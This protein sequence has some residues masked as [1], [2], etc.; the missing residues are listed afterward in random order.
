VMLQTPL[1][2]TPIAVSS[3]VLLAVLVFIFLGVG[4]CESNALFVRRSACW[5]CTC[6]LPTSA[7]CLVRGFVMCDRLFPPFASRTVDVATAWHL[8]LAFCSLR[9]SLCASAAVTSGNTFEAVVNSLMVIVAGGA[10]RACVD[11][12]CV[13]A[14]DCSLLSSLARRCHSDSRAGRLA[15][16]LH[17]LGLWPGC[18]D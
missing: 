10:V 15:V 2:Q 5:H 3:Q 9:S 16:A 7:R 12:L 4:A 11:C 13:W 8:R 18:L 17:L 14:M 6:V 1:S